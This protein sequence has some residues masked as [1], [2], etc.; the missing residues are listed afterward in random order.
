MFKP[1]NTDSVLN[2]LLALQ[3]P[4]LSPHVKPEALGRGLRISI[5]SVGD[6]DTQWSSRTV[7]RAF[8]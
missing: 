2:V 3:R 7:G 6:S 8:W 4:R 1:Q 5:S